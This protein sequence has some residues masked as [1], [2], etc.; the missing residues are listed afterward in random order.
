[1]S[2]IKPM[3]QIARSG[4]AVVALLPWFSVGK[5]YC[6]LGRTQHALQARR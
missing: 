5:E 6:Q 1:M 3:Y 4:Q 2:R